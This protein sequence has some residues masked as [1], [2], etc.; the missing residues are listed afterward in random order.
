MVGPD[1]WLRKPLN[2]PLMSFRGQR[3][4]SSPLSQDARCVHLWGRS[5][6]FCQESSTDSW[7][8]TCWYPWQFIGSFCQQMMVRRRTMRRRRRRQPDT[9][10][11][12]MTAGRGRQ[13]KT[14]Y[15]HGDLNK[16]FPPLYSMS[17]ALSHL[18]L[19]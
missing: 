5:L 3:L 16:V 8:I 11:P 19:H 13:T 17:T 18:C 12:R 2:R 4:S 1:A 15:K 6:C 7:L 14:F 10:R 9:A